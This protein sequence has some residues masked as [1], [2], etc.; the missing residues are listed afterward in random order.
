MPPPVAPSLT[1]PK[2]ILTRALL[3]LH[4]HY[5]QA[6]AAGGSRC[7]LCGRPV[8][9]RH[10]SAHDSGYA[11]GIEMRCP[12]CG[13]GDNASL[14]HLA[15]DTPAAQRFWRRHPRMRA[16]PNHEIEHAGRRV[17]LGGF[18]ARDGAARLIVLFDPA[19]FHVL[20]AWDEP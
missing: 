20:R 19:R 9:L 4:D 15:L 1:S 11:P 13:D 5:E 17:I 10:F 8:P 16:L 6:A 7:G 14:W 2:A 12:T 3:A 18:A